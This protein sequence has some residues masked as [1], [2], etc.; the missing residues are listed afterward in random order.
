MGAIKFSDS[1]LLEMK[2]FY[3]DELRSTL[4]RL[5]HIQN[6]LH[7]LGEDVDAFDFGL[8]N[9]SDV[10]ISPL[11]SSAP[12]LSTGVKVKRKTGPKPKWGKVILAVLH[13]QDTPLTYDA[14]TDQ[15]MKYKGIPVSERA[16]MKVAVT[17][18][19]FK[20]RNIEEKISTFSTG[21]RTKHI[22][23]VQWFDDE[24]KVKKEY[25]DKAAV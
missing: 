11:I 17:N 16:K 1:D 8:P 10:A 19:V 25:F 7:S 23:L 13:A 14:L 4:S 20:L 18:T 6:I 22:G 2:N 9:Y 5:L 21:G 24:G 3:K 12:N 15:V